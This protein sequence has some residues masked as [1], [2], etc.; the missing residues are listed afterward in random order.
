M[1][2]LFF[3]KTHT[4]TQ[5]Q[6]KTTL[7]AQGNMNVFTTPTLDVNIG[8]DMVIAENKTAVMQTLSVGLFY[9]LYTRRHS[10]MHQPQ[11]LLMR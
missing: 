5:M 3:V 7:I 4:N 2:T 9:C 10:L 8:P 11:V 6:Q 1:L